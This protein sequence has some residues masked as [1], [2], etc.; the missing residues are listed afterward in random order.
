MDLLLDVQRRRL[1]DQVR[2]VGH[3]LA[4][5]HQLRIKIRI[6]P[7]IGRLDRRLHIRRNKRLQLRRRRILPRRLIMRDRIHAQGW[8][9][10]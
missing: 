9:G 8:F 3:V 10:H 7:L 4:A 1:D 6:A 5:P 2:P